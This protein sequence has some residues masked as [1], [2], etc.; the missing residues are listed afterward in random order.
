MARHSVQFDC[1]HA[2]LSTDFG[3]DW[4]TKLFGEEAIASLPV[5]KSGK[6]KNHPKGFVQW[7]KAVTSGFIPGFGPV[8]A[9]QL[10]DAWIGESM[11]STKDSAL[12]GQWMGRV[13]GLAGSSGMLFQAARDAH[14][15]QEQRNKADQAE[16]LGD[17]YVEHGSLTKAIA[18]YEK[19]ATLY[20]ALGN[21]DRV[22]AIRT[23]I[24]RL[25]QT[26]VPC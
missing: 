5:L 17:D 26:L 23:E 2:A 7:R 19:A 15:S 14:A 22:I 12:R 11:F 24:T 3:R 16:C 8:Q 13:Q 18:C 20:E 21:C 6:N 25:Q 10:I 9:G 1:K 4:A